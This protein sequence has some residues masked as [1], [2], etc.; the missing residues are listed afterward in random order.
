MGHAIY[1]V[2]WIVADAVTTSLRQ[3]ELFVTS[4]VVGLMGLPFL[5]GLMAGRSRKLLRLSQIM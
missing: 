1:A 2:A 5:C 4:V 3:A